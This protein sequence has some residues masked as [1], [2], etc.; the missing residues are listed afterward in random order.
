MPRSFRSW[1][2]LLGREPSNECVDWSGGCWTSWWWPAS[3]PSSAVASSRPFDLVVRPN[4]AGSRLC[5]SITSCRSRDFIDIVDRIAKT[6]P[7]VTR[8]VTTGQ[9]TLLHVR[10]NSSLTKWTAEVDFN[11]Y[12]RPTGR[13]WITSEN[14]QSPIPVVFAKG[15]DAEVSQRAGS[16]RKSV[17]GTRGPAHGRSA[18]AVSVWIFSSPAIRA[19]RAHQRC[20]RA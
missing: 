13:Y 11:D 9:I 12:G 10:S 7:R 1:H 17:G 16:R 18:T 19:G 20:S 8:A 2:L 6:T 15:L 5:S 3:S 4:V 14:T